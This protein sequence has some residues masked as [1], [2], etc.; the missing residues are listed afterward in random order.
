MLLLGTGLLIVVIAAAGVVVALM[1]E[2]AAGYLLIALSGIG[3]GVALLI[4]GARIER[5]TMKFQIKMA[6]LQAEYNMRMLEAFSGEDEGKKSE[7]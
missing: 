3:I 6:R 4:S 5:S 2:I 7:E 1:T